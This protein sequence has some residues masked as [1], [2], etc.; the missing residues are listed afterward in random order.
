M[1]G[2][3]AITARGLAKTFRVGFWGR[4]VEALR[5]VDLSVPTG[6]VYGLVGPNGA[7][8]STTLK[9]LLGFM[10]AD[11]GEASVLGQPL[12][13]RKAR[14]QLGYLPE[15]PTFPRHL[16]ASELL[17]FHARLAGVKDAGWT[18]RR[19]ALLERVGLGKAAHGRLATYSKG[20]Q[21]RAGLAVALCADP[22]L[23]ILDE[24]MS[25]LDPLGRHDVRMLI[26]E[27]NAGGT[28]IV[29][30]SHVLGDVEALCDRVAIVAGG[31]VVKTGS[32][33]ELT[34]HAARA[35]EVRLLDVDPQHTAAL[36]AL[37]RLRT[38]GQVQ[39]W[40][41][42]DAQNINAALQVALT[43]G[44]RV[45]SVAPRSSTL[46]ELVVRMS[47]P[48]TAA[49]EATGPAGHGNAPPAVEEGPPQE[50]RKDTGLE[51]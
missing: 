1:N 31:Q 17:D 8:K 30:C 27:V 9:I 15:L 3:H 47:K 34:A 26:R 46:E 29:L 13:S 41:L 16:T 32:V 25:G 2:T 43:A 49:A 36:S 35:V 38:S 39:L 22:E 19:Q 6:E 7:G 37:G 33:A 4:R 40:E 50:G 42:N 12:G 18:G 51:P 5:H 48:A 23:L 14:H 44:C 11:R 20:M 45:L 21:Q 28:T 10:R 24:P